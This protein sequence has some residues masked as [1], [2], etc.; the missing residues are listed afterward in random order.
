MK[1]HTILNQNE[2]H[3]IEKKIRQ[4]I[5]FA[6]EYDLDHCYYEK[7]KIEIVSDTTTDDGRITIV[8]C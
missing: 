6:L 8:K 2:K 5:I 1:T 3:L 7:Q 4:E